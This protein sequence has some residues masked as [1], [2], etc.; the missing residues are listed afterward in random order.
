MILVQNTKINRKHKII[1]K[2]EMNKKT[3]KKTPT[4]PNMH[5]DEG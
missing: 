5:I 3:N 4:R 1:R 2:K